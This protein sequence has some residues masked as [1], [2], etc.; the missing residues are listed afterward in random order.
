MATSTND[1]EF[2]EH[3]ET[4][5]AKTAIENVVSHI[6]TTVTENVTEEEQ[7]NMSVNI[8]NTDMDISQEEQTVK[9]V[10]NEEN[11]DP[12][13]NMTN[14]MVQNDM[15]ISQED[16]S[17]T[18]NDNIIVPEDDA[19]QPKEDTKEVSGETVSDTT[20]LGNGNMQGLLIVGKS[21]D[22]QQH[23]RVVEALEQYNKFQK[24]KHLTTVTDN[25]NAAV[26]EDDHVEKTLSCGHKFHYRCFMNIIHRSKNI[27]IE[28][29]LCRRVNDDISKPFTDPE[30]NLHLICA[31]KVGKVRCICKTKNGT[32]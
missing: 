10:V 32:I 13:N 30:K 20:E 23:S 18:D 3:A 31:R 11:T 28:C 2:D 29:P 8:S 12:V 6:I 27:F 26:K 16:A 1:N 7:E 17:T 4:I 22:V 24:E 19:N 5:T 15:D 9:D 21:V 25:G 14:T